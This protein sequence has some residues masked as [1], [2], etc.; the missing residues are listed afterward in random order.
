MTDYSVMKELTFSSRDEFTRKPIAEKIIKLLDSA[1]DVSPMIIDGKWGTGKTEFCFKLKNLIEADNTNNYKVGYVNAFQADHAN[2]P[3]LT[4]IAEVASFYDEKDE[5][6]KNF[7]KNAV[8]YLRLISGIGLKA[9]LGFAFGRY[10]A[11]I[12]DALA[13]G[14]EEIKDGSKSL[15]DQSLESMIKDQ[16]E[17]EKN[18]STLRDALSDIASTNPIILLIDELDRCRPDF[19]VMMLE[20][21][22]HVFDVD[23]VQIILITNAE[24]LKATIKH[25]YGNETNSHDYLYKFF[26]YQVNLPTTIKDVEGRS[27]ENNVTYFK[28]TVQASRVIPQDFKDNEF[29]YEIPTFLDVGTLSLRNI[30]QIV[31]CI[32]TLVVFENI[33]R[34]KSLTIEQILVVF[35]SFVYM[36]DKDLL[37]QIVTR[38]IN[39]TKFSNFIRGTRL[40]MRQPYSRSDI[41][42][43]LSVKNLFSIAF[44]KYFVN[45]FL[46]LPSS[47]IERQEVQRHI[48][49][50]L[51]KYDYISDIHNDEYIKQVINNL[52][53]FDIVK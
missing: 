36:M 43:D 20:T 1:I 29:I 45:S 6:R 27:I 24:Q 26:K 17:A 3:L 16:V 37:N 34:S 41:L 18:L 21:I 42:N 10:A 46:D 11:D 52:L 15:I 9:G 50:S 51:G 53:L 48:K 13:D 25:S 47:T 5:K 31:R 39:P 30:E 7:I 38:H 2:E 33:E 35:L 19:A 44:D 49:I 40:D 4:L 22:K 14:M 28:A 32:E 23:N 8:P 12:P